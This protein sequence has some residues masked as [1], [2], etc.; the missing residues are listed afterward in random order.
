MFNPQ[1]LI[2]YTSSPSTFR[3][4]QQLGA[5][6]GGLAELHTRTQS[7]RIPEQSIVFYITVDSTPTACNEQTL[8][9]LQVGIV[10][11]QIG[12]TRYTLCNIKVQLGSNRIS[13]SIDFEPM[14]HSNNVGGTFQLVHGLPG[15]V[16]SKGSYGFLPALAV[17]V[18]F[19]AK[20]MTLIQPIQQHLVMPAI[21]NLLEFLDDVNVCDCSFLP[22]DCTAPIHV[23]KVL[24]I[25]ASPFFRTLFASTAGDFAEA[26]AI[27]DGQPIAMPAWRTS[28]FVLM[29]LHIYSGWLP[30]QP[31]PKRAIT[32]DADQDQEQHVG[33]VT[34]HV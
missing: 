23:S 15:V 16:T 10:F 6:E 34:K 9:P 27:K 12:P 18:Q 19:S 1:K 33:I 20:S 25:S 32:T 22:S 13:C 17:D 7:I 5:K 30:G 21:R 26:K 31:L 14:F 8:C 2:V 4:T 11:D 24:L 3:F 28:A 29:L